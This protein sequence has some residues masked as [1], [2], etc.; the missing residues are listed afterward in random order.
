MDLVFDIYDGHTVVDSRSA[1][2]AGPLSELGL[3]ADSLEILEVESSQ[4]L[5][6]DTSDQKKLVLSL[7]RKCR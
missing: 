6:L 3:D 4:A 2:G 7:E 1:Q 5:A